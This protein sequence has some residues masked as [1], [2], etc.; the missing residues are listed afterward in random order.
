MIETQ[1]QREASRQK[2]TRALLVELRELYAQVG[3]SSLHTYVCKLH[4][5]FAT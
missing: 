1:F 3:T 4:D 2:R 5:L